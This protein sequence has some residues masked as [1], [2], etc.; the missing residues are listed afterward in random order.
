MPILEVKHC[1]KVNAIRNESKIRN[2]T[3]KF[4]IF[5]SLVRQTEKCN[6]NYEEAIFE[7][8]RATGKIN[9]LP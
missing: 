5:N 1:L 3:Q 8:V 4:S 7:L 9:N 6:V 2:I